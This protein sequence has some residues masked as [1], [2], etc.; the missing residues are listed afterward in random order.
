MKKKTKPQ[1][2]CPDNPL[3]CSHPCRFCLF[4]EAEQIA[5]EITAFDRKC[6]ADEHTDTNRAWEL[7]ATARKLLTKIGKEVA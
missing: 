6:T 2:C 1:C 4:D 3:R 5:K 7:L